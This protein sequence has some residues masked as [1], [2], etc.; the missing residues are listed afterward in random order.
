MPI[1]LPPCPSKD[2]CVSSQESRKKYYVEPMAFGQSSGKACIEA[3]EAL[4]HKNF[5]RSKTLS[6]SKNQL[7]ITF[8]SALLRFVDDLQVAADDT[9]KLLH[10]RSASRIG[11]SDLGVNR[12][13]VEKIR[14]LYY[15]TT[16]PSK[17]TP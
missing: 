16:K 4:C 15:Q 13:R 1:K 14:Q 3:I 5:P 8:T 6:K 10:I 11:Y 12:K 17:Q 7:R 2:N 9:T